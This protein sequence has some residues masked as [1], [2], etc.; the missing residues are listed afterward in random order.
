MS[1][2]ASKR[3]IRSD[4]RL[5]SGTDFQVAI[6]LAWSANPDGYVFASA[7]TLTAF[8]HVNETTFYRAIK[9]LVRAGLVEKLSKGGSAYGT[10]EYRLVLDNFPED[11]QHQ[12]RGSEQPYPPLGEIPSGLMPDPPSGTQ[13]ELPMAPG[14]TPSGAASQRGSGAASQ[15]IAKKDFIEGEAPASPVEMGEWMAFKK[16]Y[17]AERPD[18]IELA[19]VMVKGG[20]FEV[21][22][23]TDVDRLISVHGTALASVGVRAI[24]SSET[25]RWRPVPASPSKG[26]SQ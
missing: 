18:G 17:R 19:R 7:A 8:A 1:W 2:Q 15:T 23:E 4:R 13:P 9:R 25:G 14:H 11:A 24:R 10:S 6:A 22:S 16:R 5:L 21:Y 12:R 26:G 3:V 20:V